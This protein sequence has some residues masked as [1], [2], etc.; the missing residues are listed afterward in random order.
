MRCTTEVSNK[1][2]T[3]LPSL[4]AAVDVSRLDDG[5][6]RSILSEVRLVQR[7]LDGLVARIGMRTNELAAVGRAAPASETL[8]GEGVVGSKQARRES[9]RAEAVE[10]VDGLETALSGGDVSGEHVDS[11]ARHTE[12]LTDE[13]RAGFNFAALITKAKELPLEPFDRLVRRQVERVVNDHGLGDSR[14]KRA[15]SE[16]RHW[17]DRE[18]GM[19]RFSG[20]LDPERYEAFTNSIEQH[21][22]HLAAASTE[23]PLAKTANLA[24]RSLVEL[25]TA[26]GGRDVR[27]RLP[28]ITVIVD[29]ATAVVGPH[30]GSVRETER[31]CDLPPESIARLSCDAIVRRVTLDRRGVPINVGRKYRTATDAQWAALKA[32]HASCGWMECDTPINWCQAHHILEWEHS[33]HTDL[34]NLI[35][36]CVRHH[37]LVHEGQWQLKLLP[38]RALKI[39][40][41]DGT[42]HA[43]VPPPRRC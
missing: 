32:V 16:F 7:C 15:A 28:S 34:D 25:I 33:G 42:H 37:H 5:G 11:L 2:L 41:P 3:Q 14:T 22:A 30:A 26:A 9:R 13:Q 35:P 38:D 1:T 43:T 4:L 39:F 17:F 10:A 21:A 31:G 40:R 20:S 19:G 24:A 6:L 12:K 8:R 18:T 36:L 29:E 23:E 27:N